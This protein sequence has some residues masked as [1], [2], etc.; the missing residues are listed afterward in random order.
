MVSVKELGSWKGELAEA[1]TCILRELERGDCEL[2]STG[3]GERGG[4]G[5]QEI[6]WKV[7]LV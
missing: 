5:A 2:R 1:D 7:W 4:G 3:V 6:R